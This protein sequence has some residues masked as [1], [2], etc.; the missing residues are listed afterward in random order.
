MNVVRNQTALDPGEGSSGAFATPPATRV[1]PRPATA[2]PPGEATTQT[3][4]PS[5]PSLEPKKIVV[6]AESQSPNVTFRRDEQGKVYYVLTDVESG[7][8]I[9]EMPPEEIR[10]VGQGI[11]DYLKQEAAKAASRVK[12]KA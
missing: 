9:R 11:A 5:A 7:R 4:R 10:K 6:P 8:E 12:I 3:L 1:P 2:A